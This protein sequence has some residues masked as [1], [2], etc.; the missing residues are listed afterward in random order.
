MIINSR[1]IKYF[2]LI[3][4]ITVIIDY[5]TYRALNFFLANIT[6]AKF[7]GFVFGT[8]FSFIANRNIT[9][10]SKK[11]FWAHLSKFCLLYLTSM[12]VNIFLNNI[13]LVFLINYTSKL[14]LSFLIATIISATIN[15]LGMKYIV[16]K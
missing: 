4:I 14:H 2:L 12:S 7:F 13:S 9:F 3:G 1:Q 16:F 15:F 6:V 10:E 8:M 5:S 11:Y